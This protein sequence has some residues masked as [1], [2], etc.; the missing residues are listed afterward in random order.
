MQSAKCK[1]IS[2]G[3]IFVGQALLCLSYENKIQ[4][5][6]EITPDFFRLA[7]FFDGFCQGLFRWVLGF[8][9]W[10]TSLSAVCDFPFLL[11][12]IASV[13]NIFTSSLLLHFLCVCIWLHF[14][15][16]ERK[17]GKWIALHFG[18]ETYLYIGITSSKLYR[19]FC[20]VSSS[21]CL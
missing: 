12:F 21:L 3:K 18:G 9:H 7:W 16:Y 17:F 2:Q 8:Y 14:T 11:V 1:I 4:K 10:L 6:N 13:N 19:S 15:L 20:L 5:P